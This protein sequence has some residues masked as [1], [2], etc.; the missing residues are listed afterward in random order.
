MSSSERVH[1]RV[2][3]LEIKE[4]QPPTRAEIDNGILNVTADHDKEEANGNPIRLDK[5]LELKTADDKAVA[6]D[7]DA[8]EK[9]ELGSE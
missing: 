2:G 6:P 1:C 7:K 4:Y 9:R 3:S 5:K 8:N